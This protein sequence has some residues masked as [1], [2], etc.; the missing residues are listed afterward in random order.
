MADRYDWDRDRDR[1]RDRERSR[2]FTGGR[3]EWERGRHSGEN[4]GYWNRERRYGSG[5]GDAGRR[6]DFGREGQGREDW[7]RENYYGREDERRNQQW[8][9]DYRGYGGSEREADYG[10]RGDW[11]RQGSWGSYG[12]RPSFNR[13]STWGQNREQEGRRGWNESRGREPFTSQGDYTGERGWG[14]SQQGYGGYGSRGS[15]SYRGGMGSFGGGMSQYGEYG[16]HA[17]RGPKGWQRPDERIRE[18]VNERLTEHPQ[19]D[20][21]NIDVQVKNCEVT[22]TGTVDERHAKRLA[23][24]IAENV[25]GV[26]DVHNQLKVQAQGATEE[27]GQRSTAGVGTTTRKS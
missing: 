8:G 11:G 26:K 9:G 7:N 4:E 25:S 10:Q 21:S 5:Y 3:G 23:E 1:D 12:N 19:I 17:G 22:L 6:E 14:S 16:R 24:D 15:E 18:D 20:A 2:E 13:E 27:S